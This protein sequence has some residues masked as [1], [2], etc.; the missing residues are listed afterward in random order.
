MNIY[1]TQSSSFGNSVRRFEVVKETEKCYFLS[2]AR[3]KKSD[4]GKLKTG[5][6]YESFVMWSLLDTIENRNRV[7]F[8]AEKYQD[9]II[10][11]AMSAKKRL[12]EDFVYKYCE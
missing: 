10:R 5:L 12:A 2:D 4:I 11:D 1:K 6:T 8:E 9:K 7:I 3:I